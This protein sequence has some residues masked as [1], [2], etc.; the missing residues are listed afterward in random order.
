L[1]LKEIKLQLKTCQSKIDRKIDIN[2]NQ[3]LLSELKNALSE[4]EDK[5][6][7]GARI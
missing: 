4:I 3:N 7:D 5:K 6:A 2:N 1:Q